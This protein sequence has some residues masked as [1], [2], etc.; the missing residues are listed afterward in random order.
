MPIAEVF[1]A[2]LITYVATEYNLSTSS[3]NKKNDSENKNF[4]SIKTFL[5]ARHNH[6][7]LL[8]VTTVNIVDKILLLTES[9][10]AILVKQ[11]FER[12]LHAPK[13]VLAALLYIIVL[14]MDCLRHINTTTTSLSTNANTATTNLYNNNNNNARK[15]LLP[16]RRF[17]K[18]VGIKFLKVLPVYPLLV[19]FISFIF[20]VV[21]SLLEHLHLPLEWLNWPIYYGTLYGPFSC[22]YFQVKEMIIMEIEEKRY[23][24]PTTTYTA[25]NYTTAGSV[26]TN[27]TG[28]GLSS[29]SST[30]K[31]RSSTKNSKKISLRNLRFAYF[32]GNNSST[33]TESYY[34]NNDDI[35]SYKG[36]YVSF[37]DDDDNDD[38]DNHEEP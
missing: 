13:I 5:S 16:I 24:I 29:R 36:E 17:L 22:V 1:N 12:L 37:Y 26:G 7:I 31:S 15:Q 28:S 6:I 35:I 23:F 4:F 25:T 18:C 11:L 3:T 30:K 20:M 33:S 2:L 14:Y 32:N 27:R 8:I 10:T 19:I 34:C 9:H 21:I 38:V